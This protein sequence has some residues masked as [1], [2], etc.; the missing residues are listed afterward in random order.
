MLSKDAILQKNNIYRFEDVEVPEWGGAVR[1]RVMSA[2]A[3][4]A[5]LASVMDV[6]SDGKVQ[7]LRVE[8][9][10]T[11]LLA[12]VIVDETGKPMFAPDEIGEMDSGVVQRLFEIAQKLN[13]LEAEAV[14]TATENFTGTQNGGSISD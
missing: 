3:R 1:L 8:K 5:F 4:S 6:G 12:Y 2:A 14:V 7:R 11:T 10:Q 13:S 9:M